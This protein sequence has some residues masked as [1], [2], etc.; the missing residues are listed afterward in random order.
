MSAP[1]AKRPRLA[2]DDSDA[3]SVVGVLPDEIDEMIG[4]DGVEWLE[5]PITSDWK[6]PV[7]AATT[8]ETI[9]FQ[10]LEAD[11]YYRAGPLAVNPAAGVRMPGVRIAG[12]ATPVIRL[13]GMTRAGTTVTAHVHGFTPYFYVLAPSWFREWHTRT[14]SS[15]LEAAL[16][17][18]KKAVSEHFSFRLRVGNWSGV[19]R[20]NTTRKL[21]QNLRRTANTCRNCPWDS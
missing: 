15:A 2:D 8:A 7:I 20:T 17:G 1:A 16:R 18:A 12:Q 6:R 13:Y 19:S 5:G 9:S 21:Y 14:F 3:E 11:S 4:E 10:W